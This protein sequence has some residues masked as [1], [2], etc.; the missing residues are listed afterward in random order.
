MRSNICTV[1][2]EKPCATSSSSSSSHSTEAAPTLKQCLE[3][4]LC[5]GQVR[6]GRRNELWAPGMEI[7]VVGRGLDPAVAVVVFVVAIPCSTTLW[8]PYSVNLARLPLL[9]GLN[10]SAPSWDPVL[11]Q[12]RRT[13]VPPI[14]A[15]R[16]QVAMSRRQQAYFEYNTTRLAASKMYVKVMLN[17]AKLT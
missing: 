16:Y 11:A 8:P 2:P 1:A 7:A 10:L 17:I 3:L 14:P 4:A 12:A 6:Q 13:R 15:H 9:G 5:L